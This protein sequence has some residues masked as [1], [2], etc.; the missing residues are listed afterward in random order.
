MLQKEKIRSIAVPV[1]S[2]F[3]VVRAALFGSVVRNEATA[4]SD[5]DIL[6]EFEDGR[7][8]LDLVGLKQQLE[9][10]LGQEVD[11]VT[12][13]SLHPSLRK[14]ILQNQEIF[15]EATAASIS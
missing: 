12:Y 7:T 2:R 1:L 6:V 9:Q 5:V 10:L 14:A 11:V 8:L 4:E 3:G 15:Y 13:S